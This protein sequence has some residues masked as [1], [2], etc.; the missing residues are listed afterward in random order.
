MRTLTGGFGGYGIPSEQ[1]DP[2]LLKRKKG[3]TETFFSEKEANNC[4]ALNRKG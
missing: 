2:I 3:N 1:G 4:P